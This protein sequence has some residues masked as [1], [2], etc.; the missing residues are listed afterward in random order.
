MENRKTLIHWFRKGLRVHDNP[1]LT[2]V[3]E[4]ANSDVN[5][6]EVRPIFI[7][8]PGIVQWLKVGANR[9]RFLQQSLAD[10]HNQL[11]AL[12]SRLYVVRGKPN[13]VFERIFKEWQTELL[14]FETDIE[15]YS[16]K[17]DAEVV[18]LAHQLGV[19]VDTHCSHT[20]YNPET[21]IKKN[22]GTAPL[23]YQKFLS[24]V[25]KLKTPMPLPTPVALTEL[26]IPQ[27]DKWEQK[28]EKCYDY[29]SMEELVKHPEELGENK[30]LGG[31]TEGLR[32]LEQ[33]LS[34]ETWV[35]NFEKPN[36]AP[37]SLE[38]ST[39]VLSPYLKFGCLSSRLFYQRLTD[40]LKKHP[41]HSKPPVSLK[42][43]LMWREFF[44]TAATDEPDFDRMFGNKYCIQIPWEMND[45][46]LDA[47][48]HARTGY[49]F[50]D[51]IMRQL[52]QEGW[53]HHLARHAVACFLT[54]G[55]LWISW[56]SGLRVFEELLLDHDWALNAGNWLWLSASAFFHSYFRVYSPVAFGKKTD[57][58]ASLS[59]QKEYGCVLGED[60]PHRIVVHEAVYKINVQRMTAAYKVNR[61]VCTGKFEKEEKKSTAK[62]R[63]KDSEK[64]LSENKKSRN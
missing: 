63:M 32:R 34:N 21:V 50:I 49:P 55:D 44:Y 64:S 27:Q 54:R 9:W 36:T 23:T 4:Q 19:Q 53:I 17:R 60:Y 20:I 11:V 47:W 8:D 26:V 13:E 62:R 14:T 28:D 24:I 43:Q 12:K 38:P 51:A 29:P 3:F 45:V 42:G 35:I 58:T 39:T 48:T 18:K 41:N 37:N 25:E 5:K 56:Q 52:R 6:Y 2:R 33:S 31:E 22:L 7:L 15:P 46:Y 40:I 57:P 61:E 10:L 30:F 16:V 59:A 1:G